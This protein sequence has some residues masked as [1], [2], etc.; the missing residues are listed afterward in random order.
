MVTLQHRGGDT[1]VTALGRCRT[2]G[3]GTSGDEERG[4]EAGSRV[5]MTGSRKRG[6]RPLGVP[7]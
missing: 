4:G 1:W 7:G 3:S 2:E 6:Q 5:R